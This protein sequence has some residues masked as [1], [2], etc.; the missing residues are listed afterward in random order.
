MTY[1]SV[2]RMWDELNDGTKPQ[3]GNLEDARA[4]ILKLAAVGDALSAHL[5]AVLS[6]FSA[7]HAAAESVKADRLAELTIKGKV[8]TP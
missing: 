6:R 1:E 8:E 4:H 2:M 3:P 5:H 7:E